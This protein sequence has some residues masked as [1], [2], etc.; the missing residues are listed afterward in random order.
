M[1]YRAAITSDKNYWETPK[2][3]FDELNNE[4]RF[5]LD[6]AASDTNHKCDKYFTESDDGLSQNWGGYVVWCNPPYGKQ[7]TANWVKK[8]YDECEEHG[9]TVV[10]LL[11]SRTDTRWFHN[12]IYG[13]HEIRFVKG[14][15]RFELDGVPQQSATF[16]SMIVVFRKE[17]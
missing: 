6:A 12:Y 8:A 16:S 15:L 5:T 4:F 11:A 9:A 7:A 10:M 14:R 17:K 13:K 3:L 2:W 1:K